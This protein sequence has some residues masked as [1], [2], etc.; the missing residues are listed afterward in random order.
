[1]ILYAILKRDVVGISDIYRCYHVLDCPSKWLN[2]SKFFKMA[3]IFQYVCYLGPNKTYQLE[4]K[5]TH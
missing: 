4:G 1:M 5:L 2:Y 3:R